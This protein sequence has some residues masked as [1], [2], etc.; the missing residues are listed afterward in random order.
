MSS[1]VSRA[2]ALVLVLG[3]LG[4]G[5]APPAPERDAALDQRVTALASELRCAV[6]QNQSLADSNAGL[7]VDLRNEIRSRMVQG[8]SDAQIVAFLVE[9]YGEFVLYRPPLRA[10]T[11]LLWF[12]PLLLLALGLLALYR[13]L[14]QHS[15]APAPT[16]STDERARAARLLAASNERN[17]P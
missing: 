10:A 16:L 5:A 4:A 8:E 9:R 1:I 13:R 7:A 12:G 17:A 2:L 11:L 15:V 3:A 14:T 6:C